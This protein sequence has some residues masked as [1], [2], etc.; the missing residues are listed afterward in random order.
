MKKLKIAVTGGIGS[1]KSEFCSYIRSKDFPVIDADSFAKNI[2]LTDPQVK[3]RVIQTFGE[4]SYTQSGL[5][6]KYLAQAVFSDAENVKKINS[7]V[8]PV[9][10]R[11]IDDEMQKLLKEHSA[12]FV[13]AALIYEAD[14]DEMF[15]YVVVVTADEQVRIHRIL[16]REKTT[17]EEVRSRMENQIPESTK[18]GW[19]DFVIENNGTLS[20]LHSRTDFFLSLIKTITGQV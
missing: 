3:Q 6:R 11:K 12:V 14:M 7:I 5:N 15:D 10:I 18:K 17:E 1:G 2:L 20:E 13:E 8:H 16:Q 19:A 9:V 4:E